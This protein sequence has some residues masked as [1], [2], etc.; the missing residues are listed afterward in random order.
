M[1]ASP[2][3]ATSILRKLADDYKDTHLDA[4]QLVMDDF[5][6]DD[7]ITGTDSL[8]RATFLHAQLNDLLS[9]AG[10]LLRKWHS[11]SSAVL[12]T[13]HESLKESK[14]LQ[15]GSDPSKLTKPLESIGISIKMCFMSLSQYSSS[16]PN[17]TWPLPLPVYLT[18]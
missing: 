11:S 9:K 6:V 3:L 7:L 5:Y 15:I 16:R 4:Y 13:I 17:V 14:P 18:C 8:E 1:A 12:N 2:F 10:M